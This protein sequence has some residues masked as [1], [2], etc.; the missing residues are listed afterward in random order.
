MF[1]FKAKNPEEM[2]INTYE[3]IFEVCT[4]PA[5]TEETYTRTYAPLLSRKAFVHDTASED[6]VNKN[7]NKESVDK[8]ILDLLKQLRNELLEQY[9]FLT[10]NPKVIERFVFCFLACVLFTNPGMVPCP[11][12]L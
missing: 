2:T 4:S 7:I 6:L 11:P 8:T 12:Y 3:D 10:T 1:P 9:L 5:F